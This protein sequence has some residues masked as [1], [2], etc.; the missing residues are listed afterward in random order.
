V[1]AGGVVFFRD[2]RVASLRWGGPS[3]AATSRDG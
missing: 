2:I 3:S 1:S